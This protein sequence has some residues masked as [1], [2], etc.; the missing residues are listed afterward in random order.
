MG[1][2]DIAGM[3]RPVVDTGFDRQSQTLGYIGYIG[4]IAGMLFAAAVFWF[5]KKQRTRWTF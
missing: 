3:W 5:W 4:Y 2:K 1:Q